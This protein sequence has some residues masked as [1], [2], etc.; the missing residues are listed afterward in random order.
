MNLVQARKIN[1]AIKKF[2]YKT[3][4]NIVLEDILMSKRYEKLHTKIVSGI[5]KQILYFAKTE[6]VDRM[7]GLEKGENTSKVFENVLKAWILLSTFVE[8]GDIADYLIWVA[9]EGGQGAVDKIGDGKFSLTNEAFLKK[10]NQ[11]SIEALKLVDK[12]T[13]AW[14]VSTIVQGSKYGLSSKDIARSLRDLAKKKAVMR[15]DLI[16]EHETALIVGAIEKLVYKKSRIKFCRWI[17][18]RDELVCPVCK[19]NEDIGEIPIDDVF[20]SEV[21]YPPAHHR[22]YSDDTE[23]YTDSGWRL[24]KN[25]SGKELFMSFNPKT[26]KMEWARAKNLISYH[27]SGDMIRFHHISYDLLVTPDHRMFAGFRVDRGKKG[28]YMEYRFVSAMKLAKKQEFYLPRTAKWQGNKKNKININGSIF[29][30]K[31]F[32]K[33]MG[34]YLSEGSV[35]ER[36]KK[37]KSSY[38]ISI[39]QS[40]DKNRK[41]MFDEIKKLPFRKIYLGKTKIYIR[42]DVVAKYLFQF[43]HSYQKFIPVE[44]KEAR[45]EIISE[46]LSAYHLGDGSTTTSYWKERKLKSSWKSI[47]T[48]SKRMAEDLGELIFKVGLYPGFSFEKRKGKVVRFK[49]GDYT[50]KTDSYVVRLNTS[51]HAMYQKG[52]SGLKIDRMSYNGIVYGVELVKNHILLVRRNNKTAWSGNCRCFLMPITQGGEKPWTGK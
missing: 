33:F 28:R 4:V 20:P 42:D 1:K 16:T 37:T 5:T 3:R 26:M 29:V 39:A 43:G 40:N 34:Y 7:L 38:E 23:I 35:I 50:I 22:C 2:F 17:T 11:R 12:T 31:D 48:S 18:A 47:T 51:G 10:I 36:K 41:K 24:F 30:L 8:S 14:I 21:S 25:V 19:G 9:N 45:I 6:Q 46:F 52:R 49:N 13:Q 27:Y 32:A 44:I 15:A